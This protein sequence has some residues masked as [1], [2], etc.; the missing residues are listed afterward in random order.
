M[1]STKPLTQ[2]Q[3]DLLR[4]GLEALL[5]EALA[6]RVQPRSEQQVRELRAEVWELAALL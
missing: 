4:L 5:R 2:R 3:R 6:D 1:R